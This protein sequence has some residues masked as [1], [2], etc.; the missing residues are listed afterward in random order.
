MRRGKNKGGRVGTRVDGNRFRWVGW[1]GG[2]GGGGKN[3][4][5]GM[6]LGGVGGGGGPREGGY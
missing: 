6:G 2:G 4:G 1:R 3:C 5:G